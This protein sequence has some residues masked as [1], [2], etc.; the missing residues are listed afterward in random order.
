MTPTAP[1]KRI[2][3]EALARL[4]DDCTLEDVQYELY[5]MS[6]VRRGLGE[7]KRGKGIPHAQARKR[8][9]KWLGK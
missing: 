1:V 7:I 6:K 5:V 8:M 4:P 2:V 9:L 3:R